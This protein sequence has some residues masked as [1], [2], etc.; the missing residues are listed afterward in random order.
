M[1]LPRAVFAESLV[2]GI[3]CQALL[4]AFSLSPHKIKRASV[5]EETPKAPST[6]TGAVFLS[7]ASQDAESRWPELLAY[8]H[9][10]G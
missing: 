7:Y 1:N 10:Q 5:G 4:R 2:S 6:P 9:V 3:A 8:G